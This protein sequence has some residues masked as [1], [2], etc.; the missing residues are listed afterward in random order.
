[1][2]IWGRSMGGFMMLDMV[3]ICRWVLSRESGERFGDESLWVRSLDY[4]SEWQC[5]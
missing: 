5:F 4:F 1:M 3:I 2:I